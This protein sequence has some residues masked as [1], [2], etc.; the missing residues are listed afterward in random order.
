[1]ADPYAYY[2]EVDLSA[3]TGEWIAIIDDKIVSHDKDIKKV[4]REAKER[5]PGK[6]PLLAKVP[7]E[8]ALIF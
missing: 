1:V 4:Y 2:I 5:F 6:R 3:Y 7:E 8:K